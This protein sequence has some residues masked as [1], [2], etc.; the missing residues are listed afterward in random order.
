MPLRTP[1]TILLRVISKVA[2]AEG[3]FLLVQRLPLRGNHHFDS[4]PINLLKLLCVSITCVRAGYF[5]G[6][7]QNLVGLI[8]LVGSIALGDAASKSKDILGRI[9]EY[10]LGQFAA[11]EGK[12]GGQFYTPDQH[13]EAAGGNVRAIRFLLFLFLRI[14]PCSLFAKSSSPTLINTSLLGLPSLSS[15]LIS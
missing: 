1:V 8:D 6:L 9:Y 10:F 3:T 5:A 11:A 14:Y 7:L 13:C 15:P 4:F 2:F 12:K